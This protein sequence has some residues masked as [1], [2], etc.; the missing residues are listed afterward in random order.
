MIFCNFASR[1][2]LIGMMSQDIQSYFELSEQE[3]RF[4]LRSTSSIMGGG[5]SLAIKLLRIFSIFK[6]FILTFFDCNQIC[7]TPSFEGDEYLL[8]H[9]NQPNQTVIQKMEKEY[10][11]TFYLL[12]IQLLCDENY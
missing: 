6:S 9:T 1:T 12:Q 3:V 10:F 8:A 11:L 2:I 5:K 7:Y 4:S